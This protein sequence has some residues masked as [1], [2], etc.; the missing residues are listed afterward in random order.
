M[1][2]WVWLSSSDGTQKRPILLFC[3]LCA[4]LYRRLNSNIFWSLGIFKTILFNPH[5]VTFLMGDRCFTRKKYIW[6]IIEA[7]KLGT[8]RVRRFSIRG[9]FL[10]MV[11]LV[12]HEMKRKRGWSTW[13]YC[14]LGLKLSLSLSGWLSFI[15]QKC[16]G[17]W[18]LVDEEDVANS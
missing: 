3:R 16:E 5:M 15:T 2:L 4:W 12:D 8:I 13:N 17:D 1:V 11:R 6:N 10:G 14:R 9:I 7:W 18:K